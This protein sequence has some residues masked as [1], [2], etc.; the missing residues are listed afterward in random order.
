MMMSQMLRRMGS[1][2]SVSHQSRQTWIIV[3]LAVLCIVGVTL[4]SVSVGTRQ[5]EFGDV[6]YALF[7]GD[8]SNV[9]G[10]I[11]WKRVP[12]TVFGLLA[13]AALGVAGLLMQS[14]TRNPI[15]DP[16]ILGVNSGA[17]LAVVSGIAFLGITTAAQYMVLAI[18]GAAAAA[19]LVYGVGS[20]GRG[21]ATPLKLALAG[22]AISMALTSLVSVI[23]M[24]NTQVMDQF[25]FWQVGSISG[26]NWDGIIAFL[27]I[28]IIGILV[29][30]AIA[31]ALEVLAMGDEAAVGLG[32]RPGL[33]RLVSSI[34]AV[35]LCGATT[36][37]A[38]PIS[39]VGLMVPH[40]VRVITHTTMRNQVFL[41]ALTG[42]LLLVV[43]D[44]AGRVLGNMLI[45]S[46]TELEVGI[47]TAFIG[48]PVF[49]AIA[50][51]AGGSRALEAN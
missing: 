5:L 44:V 45:A 1:S 40:A 25:R 38:G 9:T 35:A 18:A 13:G 14:V 29:A 34:A 37:I 28:F 41:C 2:Q 26:A 6:M 36:A 31:P 24:P 42:A 10:I 33:V 39:F 50:V 21:G 27:P 43:S 16:S 32:A 15:A 22:T 20:A 46:S 51:R 48:A 17:S 19:I 3:A 7:T 4:V 47:I 11:V 30:F 12:R 8:Q 23:V 49:I